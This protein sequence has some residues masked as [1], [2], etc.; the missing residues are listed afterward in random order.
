MPQVEEAKITPETYFADF[1]AVE[2]ES[3]KEI[4]WLHSL[5]ARA[6][7]AFADLGVPT[8]RQ[9]A[10]RFTNITPLTRI[11]FRLAS[12]VDGAAGLEDNLEH[13]SIGDAAARL[14]FV[15]GYFSPSLS[16]LS[17]LPEGVIAT[18]LR[19]SI[20]NRVLEQHIGRYA[21]DERE[22]F[23]ALNTAFLRDGA[24]IR[25][26]QGVGLERPIQVIYLR[27]EGARNT[28]SYPR[29]LVVVERGAQAQVIESHL[30]LAQEPYFNNAVTELVAGEDASIEHL[31]IQEESELAFHIANIVAHQN[32]A[33]RVLSHS[34]SLGAHL[35]RHDIRA[36][37]A[38]EGAECTLNGLYQV[39][40]R[41]HVDHH[42]TLDHAMPHCGSRE[43]YRGV[44]DGK[45]SA[46][47]N[48]AII[49]RKDAQKTDA[50]QSNKNL[51]LSEEATINTKPELQILADDVR[52][53]HGATVGQLDPDAVFYL[54]ARGIGLDAAR[55][56]LT[57][58]FA[59]DVIARIR[60]GPARERLEATLLGR[61]SV[62][63]RPEE[64][65]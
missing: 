3:A 12:P 52:C 59:N 49:V 8:T 51:L 19:Q 22:A 23:V 45:S 28:V 4:S 29:T 50:I 57:R 41:Q 55:H 46:V 24:F 43:Y 63:W 2:K 14:V 60:C 31:K 48:G 26:A 13:Y 58:A 42:T 47:F 16:S 18:N 62:G 37:L 27:M 54:R 1:R 7:E 34:I 33:S 44:L 17:D 32:R 39:N 9:E 15:N 6:M 40:G 11:P 38:G 36:V 20:A 25:V 64:V 53:T 21:D 56:L 35:A 65:L 10:W 61:L 30:G 5:R